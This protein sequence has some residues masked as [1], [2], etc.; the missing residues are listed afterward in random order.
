MK[1]S[2]S[3]LLF[4]GLIIVFIGFWGY[5]WFDTKST[6]EIKSIETAILNLD[7]GKDFYQN[8]NAA[9]L[10]RRKIHENF[11]I[12]KEIKNT[13]DTYF[14]TWQKAKVLDA[15]SIQDNQ[16]KIKLAFAPLV[17]NTNIDNNQLIA[18]VVLSILFIAFL[19]CSFYTNLLRDAVGDRSLLNDKKSSYSLS[20][21][22]LAI[23]ITTIASFY[24]YAILWDQREITELNTTAL[25]LMG[26]SA[27]TFATGAILDTTEIE[28][29]IPRTQ[30]EPS[31]GNALKDI[32][33]DKNGIS[34]HRFQNVVWTIVAI[35]IYFYR[36]NNPINDSVLPDLSSTLLA[37]TGISSATYLVLKTR[38][39]VPSV[40]DNVKES[41]I[42]LIPDD[43]LATEIKTAFPGI[44]FKSAD[45]NIKNTG[46]ADV[47]KT[48]QKADTKADFI[49][50]DIKPGNYEINVSWT[51]KVNQNDIKLIG[52][53]S[54]KID[55]LN[56]VITV[57]LHL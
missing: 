54:T 52:T 11:I 9:E 38:E 24:I 48:K 29:G 1:K 13:F 20:R 5:H 40:N 8:I 50:N 57:K 21:T 41:I 35:I 2:T 36:Y 23:W 6:K 49:V 31:S 33:S 43:S 10:V 15:K 25:T 44:D 4:V 39:N 53:T 3:N 17:G 7:P 45:I 56:T 37:L 28:S 26:I 19:Y 22:Q 32:L 12:G 55:S 14:T 42:H 47:P 30:D 51:G 46:T 18:V 16:E 27:G 34:I